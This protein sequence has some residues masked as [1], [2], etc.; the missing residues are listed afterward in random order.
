MQIITVNS[1]FETRVKQMAN[2]AN[3][4]AIDDY[5][6]LNDDNLETGLVVMQDA[7]TGKTTAFLAIDKETP[8]D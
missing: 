2:K 3:I 7:K 4:A 5:I 1:A 8:E 6:I